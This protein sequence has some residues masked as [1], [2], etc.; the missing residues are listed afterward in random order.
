MCAAAEPR[1]A[2]RPGR[3]FSPGR[4][5]PSPGRRRPSATSQR[6]AEC[7]SAGLRAAEGRR[8]GRTLMDSGQPSL[9]AVEGHCTTRLH[10]F[11]EATG[12]RL[13]GTGGTLTI[14]E[15]RLLS[16]GSVATGCTSDK[17]SPE[18]IASVKGR[19]DYFSQEPERGLSGGGQAAFLGGAGERSVERAG[20]RT[21]DRI[22][23]P[24]E[25]GTPA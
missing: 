21:E 10:T 18:R 14:K 15:G 17:K 5:S 24:A 3:P 4:R 1:G 7:G 9:G 20:V 12:T 6:S 8:G 25:S 2:Q 23:S 13:E 19:P 22:V 16:N 11:T